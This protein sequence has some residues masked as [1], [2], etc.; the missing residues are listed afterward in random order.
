MLVEVP[1]N[2]ITFKNARD[3]DQ[4][5]AL[6]PADDVVRGMVEVEDVIADN[7]VLITTTDTRAVRDWLKDE[8][9]KYRMR[10]RYRVTPHGIRIER[11][12][13]GAVFEF[14]NYVDAIQFALRWSGSLPQV[15]S[16]VR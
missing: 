14:Q 4:A 5:R 8:D 9:L 7:T 15:S 13:V 16:S 10:G 12:F 3:A 11:E 1:L 6:I 2:W